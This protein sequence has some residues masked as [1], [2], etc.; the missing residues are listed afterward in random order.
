M[1]DNA[2]ILVCQNTK[3]FVVLPRASS[4]GWE[5]VTT[6]LR[7]NI[8]TKYL[9]LNPEAEGVKMIINNLG[10]IV[11]MKTVA[12]EAKARMSFHITF[13]ASSSNPGAEIFFFSL[14]LHFS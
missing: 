12:V 5:K 8:Q 2:A 3:L 7:G 4:G 11:T 9:N 14:I 1:L 6:R 10:Y 13:F